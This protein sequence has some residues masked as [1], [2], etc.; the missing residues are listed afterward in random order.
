MDYERWILDPLDFEFDGRGYRFEPEYTEEELHVRE[1]EAQARAMEAPE[2]LAE[3]VPRITGT[4]WCACDKCRQMPTE[5]ESRCCREW[6]LILTADMA[7]LNVSVDEDD[8]LSVCIT[9][10]EVRQLMYKPV[11][12][13]FFWV[14]KINWKKCPTPEGPNGK[15]SER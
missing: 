12:E 7:S 1:M 2:A 6:D 8:V 9:D 15:L 3:D 10:N 5:V 13:T 11:L 4:W 14:P